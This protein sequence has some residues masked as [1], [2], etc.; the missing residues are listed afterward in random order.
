MVPDTTPGISVQSL[1]LQLT[2]NLMCL[3]NEKQ[4]ECLLNF[5]HY[6]LPHQFTVNDCF[7]IQKEVLKDTCHMETSDSA[8]K[9]HL[10]KMT[11]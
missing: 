3:Y 5:T 2:S 10:L 4:W 7:F 11:I 6:H 1:L 8:L 9:T